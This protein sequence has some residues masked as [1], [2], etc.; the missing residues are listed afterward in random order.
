M[1]DIA[2]ENFKSTVLKTFPDIDPDAL[3]LIFDKLIAR[4]IKGG[5][6]GAAILKAIKKLNKA[7]QIH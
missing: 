2:Y 5:E 7:N 6:A 3:R 4:G 1:I